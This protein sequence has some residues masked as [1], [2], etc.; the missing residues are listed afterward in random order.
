MRQPEFPRRRA[1]LER[2]LPA[3]DVVWSAA[4]GVRGTGRRR[5]SGPA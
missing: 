4:R 1:N 3:A 5:Q 2:L